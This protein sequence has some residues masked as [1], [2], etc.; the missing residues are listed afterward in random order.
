M[1]TART[2]SPSPARRAHR[3]Q[4][5]RAALVYLLLLVLSAIFFAPFVWLVLTSF[6]PEREI[7]NTGLPTRLV[8]ENYEKGLTHFPFALYLRNTLFLCTVNVVGV[9]ISSSLVAYGLARIPWRGRNILFALLLSTM[10]LPSQV[11]MVPLFAVFKW[12][13]WIDTF[14]PLTVP[15]FLGNA[16]F[17]FLLRQF[18]LTIPSDLTDAARLDGCSEFDIYRKVILP[19]ATPALATVA[20]FT[21]MNTWNDFIGPLIYLY[22]DRKFTLSLGLASFTSQYGTFWG[23]LMAVSTIMTLPIIALYFFTQR[24]F[25]QGITMSGIKG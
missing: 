22:D 24:T 17:I 5:P 20:L 7:F 13:G 16:F 14:L 19:L 8:L 18:F 4:W 21:F 25:I 3:P 9:L 23:Q 10:M 6:K 2:E 12:L 15:A 11:T 1:D